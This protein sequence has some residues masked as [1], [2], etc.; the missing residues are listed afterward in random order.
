M[1]FS[2]II[3]LFNKAPYIEN[4][5]QSVLAQTYSDWELIVVDDGSRDESA[6]IVERILHDVNNAILIRQ[7]NSGVS[8]A[9]NN[10]VAASHGEY[11]CFLDAD[12]WWEPTFLEG[13]NSL[14][15]DCPQARLFAT[16][17][18]YVKNGRKQVKLDI[19]TGYFNYCQVYAK[20]LCQPVW[21]GAT[22][23]SR[24]TFEEFGGFKPQ[25]KLGEDFELWIRIVL[26]Y[27]VAFL[28]SPM[29]NYNQD[30]DVSFRGTHHLHKPENHMLWNLDYLAEEEKSNPDFKQLMDNLRVYGLQN[31][32]LSKEFHDAAKEQLAKVDWTLQPNKW[33]KYYDYPLWWLR[34]RQRVLILGSRIKQKICKV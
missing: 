14:I 11:V 18:Y 27:P 20:S 12:D 21:T 24:E 3:P 15:A 17:Y 25:L 4:A 22:C 13:M 32:F 16:N 30:V 9:R 28:N 6:A 31:H 8:T 34:I 33:K 2:V 7:E 5:L 19:P 29:S 1:R 10:G 26:R 23:M